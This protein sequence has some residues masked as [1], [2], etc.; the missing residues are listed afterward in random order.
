MGPLSLSLESNLDA[1]SLV[2]VENSSQRMKNYA[3]AHL[4]FQEF[5]AAQYLVRHPH[6]SRLRNLVRSNKYCRQW[7]SVWNFVAGLLSSNPE[8]LEEFFELLQQE[9]RDLFGEYHTG[10]LIDCTSESGSGLVGRCR[11]MV[12]NSISQWTDLAVNLEQID[13]IGYRMME[14]PESVLQQKLHT[15]P[16]RDQLEVLVGG[17][18]KNISEDCCTRIWETAKR[19]NCAKLAVNCLSGQQSLS[20]EV[21]E[22]IC[23]VSLKDLYRICPRLP[24]R[25]VTTHLVE[26]VSNAASM[27][28]GPEV[29]PETL[30]RVRLL[31]Y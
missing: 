10:L 26:R 5:F 8:R 6:P 21:F 31:S 28:N 16:S 22:E 27:T 29:D 25:L 1:I 20:S 14:L 2:R 9:P 3:F 24:D 12:F 23:D 19:L 11:E 15:S 4:T 30:C 17:I 18:P 7:R 13:G